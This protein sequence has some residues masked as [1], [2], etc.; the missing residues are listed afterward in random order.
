IGWDEIL[1][2]G[3]APRA[4]VMS[5]RGE[6]GGIAAARAGHDAVMSPTSHCYFD[7]V[8]YLPGNPEPRRGYI[9]LEHVYSYEPIPRELDAGAARHILGAQANIWTER[10]PT[11]SDVERMTFPRIL[12]LSDVLWS[13][14]SAKNW[15]DFSQ[16]LPQQKRKL[17]SMGVEYFEV[18]K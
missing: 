9:S 8:Q 13:P 17:K 14:K 16:R 11:L 2:G 4:T 10:I 18:P 5:W 7:Y 15:K 12:A 1:E 6:K 3:L